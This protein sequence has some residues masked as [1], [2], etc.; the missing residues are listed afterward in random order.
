MTDRIASIAARQL[1]EE[2]GIEIVPGNV[3]PRIGQTRAPKTL[4]RIIRRHGE[5]HARLMLSMIAETANNAPLLD[6]VGM[7]TMS[8]VIRACPG[9]VEH[10]AGELQEFFDA[11]PLTDLHYAARRAYG[12]VSCRA[13]LFGMIFERILIRFGTGQIEMFDDRRGAA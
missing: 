13:A 10:R 11:L 4:E 5:A 7:W 12:I 9:I 8:D 1:L 3:Q 2:F 6:E